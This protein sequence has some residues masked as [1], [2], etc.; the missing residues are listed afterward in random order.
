M[1]RS[2]A[3]TALR[4]R[5][6][7]TPAIRPSRGSHRCSGSARRPHGPPVALPG[8]A[9]DRGAVTRGGR[10]P[11]ALAVRVGAAGVRVARRPAPLPSSGRRPRVRPVA[12]P[13]AASSRSTWSPASRRLLGLAVRRVVRVR[14]AGRR[15]GTVPVVAGLS[16]R[17]R[18]RSAGRGGPGV[19]RTG[20]RRLRRRRPL[21]GGPVRRGSV[22]RGRGAAGVAGSPVPDDGSVDEGVA[23]GPVGVE[24]TVD[25]EP[26]PPSASWLDPLDCP[27][28]G[29]RPWSAG[30]GTEMPTW[31][32]VSDTNRWMPEG[33]A[34]AAARPPKPA[35]TTT[36]PARPP[37]PSAAGAR[38]S[39]L[40]ASGASWLPACGRGA[41]EAAARRP[42]A[43]RNGSRVRATSAHSTGRSAGRSYARHA[44]RA[45]APLSSSSASLIGEVIVVGSHPL[46]LVPDVFSGVPLLELGAPA[47]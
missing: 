39:P 30:E 37:P 19:R 36:T 14:R 15:S 44:S 4:P 22:G 6:H 47:A 20:C 10:R 8:S 17:G 41:R 1:F 2:G 3:A 21:R 32:S 38:P 27:G 23:S 40:R 7:E 46:R 29:D 12:S 11:A 42:A 45:S 28:R 43:L 25:F 9:C 5:A 26:P 33:S 31:S 18:A 13:P 16:R 24:P 35:T 34:S